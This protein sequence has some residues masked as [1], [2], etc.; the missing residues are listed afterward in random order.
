[1]IDIIFSSFFHCFSWV[2]VNIVLIGD[3]DDQDIG[4]GTICGIW[5]QLLYSILC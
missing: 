3:T 1:M 2:L 5:V 4:T